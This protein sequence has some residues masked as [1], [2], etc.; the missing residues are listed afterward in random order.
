MPP[1]NSTVRTFAPELWG[2]VDTFSNLY[3]ETYKFSREDARALGGV[4][5]HFEKSMTFMGIATRMVPSLD[6]DDEELERLAYTSAIASRELGMILEAAML[7][8][9]SSVDCAAKVIR[10]VHLKQCRG[11]K[12]STRSLFNNFETII[13]LPEQIKTPLRKATWFNQLCFIRDELTHLATGSCRRDLGSE[14]IRYMH[15]G[16]RQGDGVLVIDDFFAWFR[17][18]HAEVNAFLG[19]VFQFL[20]AGLK[21]TPIPIM[22]GMVD[23]RALI[24]WVIPTESI[25]FASGTC[26]SWQWFELPTLPTCPLVEACGAYARTRPDVV[27]STIPPWAKPE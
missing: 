15:V 11:F 16:I 27:P 3:Q 25:T 22:C 14:A 18:K 9:Y 8:L 7:E 5:Q 13:G 19:E 26:G 2:Q 1:R 21:S 4:S 17:T 10:A 12:A 24:R 20:L 23:G 6:R